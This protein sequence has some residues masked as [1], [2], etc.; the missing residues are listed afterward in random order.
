MRVQVKSVLLL[1]KKIIRKTLHFSFSY[2]ISTGMSSCKESLAP[3]RA[4]VEKTEQKEKAKNGGCKI[5]QTV[6]KIGM[7]QAVNNSHF[8]FC[9]VENL[10]MYARH[11]FYSLEPNWKN[12]T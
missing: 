7:G 9:K 11:D 8:R 4:A 2:I 5:L 1:Q 3:L 12:I 6:S 10:S